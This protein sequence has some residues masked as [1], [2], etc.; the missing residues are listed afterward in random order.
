VSRISSVFNRPG[1]KALIP[2]VTIGY[3]DIEATLKVVPLLAASSCDIVELGM[4]FSDPL[5]DGA[6]IQNA[7]Y[8]AL[9]NGVTV[10]TCFKIARQLRKMV[11][12]PLLF[13]TY[14]NPVYYY[15]L[16][17]FCDECERCGIDGLI[18]PDLPPEE[19]ADLEE[20]LAQRNADLIYLLAPTS[21]KERISL[22]AEH[23]SGFIYLV[24][25]VGVTGAR[26]QLNKNLDVF[27][28]RVRKKTD[29]PLCVGFGISTPAQARDSVHM[30]DGAIIGSRIIQLMEADPTLKKVEGFIKDVRAALDGH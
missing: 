21:T 22:V 23:S 2:Y 27:V 12:I 30:A 16:E 6:T 26:K 1:H 7:S 9:T 4:P 17:A 18:I 19:G 29:K 3:P 24:S 25:V 28:N 8:R 20:M 10:H 14:Y 15:G 5:A 11:D 13:M